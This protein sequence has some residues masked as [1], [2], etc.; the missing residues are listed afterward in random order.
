MNVGT[1]LALGMLVQPMVDL[2]R[3]Q[4]QLGS[5]KTNAV[6]RLLISSQ[7]HSPNAQGR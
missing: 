5:R 6:D 3:Y 7:C 1:V 4:P 2:T